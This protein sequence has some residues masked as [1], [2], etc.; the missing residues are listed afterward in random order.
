MASTAPPAAA[1]AAAAVATRDAATVLPYVRSV[2]S[3]LLADDSAIE[4]DLAQLDATLALAPT[5]AAVS[6]FAS[7]A[8]CPILVVQRAL[9]E[10]GSAPSYSVQLE[11]RHSGGA[12]SATFLALIKKGTV[13]EADKSL[14]QQLHVINLSED[15]PFETLHAYIHNAVSPFFN[16]CVTAK[17]DSSADPSS[18]ASS[19]STGGSSSAAAAGLASGS[20]TVKRKMA[21]L[22][23]SLLQLQQNVDIPEVDLQIHPLITQTIAKHRSAGTKATVDDF[24]VNDSTFVFNLQSCVDRWIKEIQKVTKLDR[25]PSHG[26]ALV[27][28]A[29]WVNLER[30]LQQVET[31]LAADDVVLTLDLLQRANRFTAITKFRSDIQLK[32]AMERVANYNVVMKNFPINEALAAP[33]VGRIITAVEDIFNHFKKL[34]GSQYPIPRAIKFVEAVSRDI[35]AHIVDVLQRRKLMQLPFDD[36]EQLMEHCNQLFRR[37][38][39]HLTSFKNM[40]RDVA[41]TSTQANRSQLAIRNELATLEERLGAVQEFRRHHEQ[42]RSVILRV[43]RTASFGNDENAVKAA[44]S[45]ANHTTVL[46]LSASGDSNTQAIDDINDAFETVKNVDVLDLTREG[47][48]LWESA[49]RAYDERVDRVET[50]ITA[51]LRDQLGTAK[52]ANEMFRIF[53]RFNALFVRPRIQGA[54]KEYQT[55]LIQR[56]KDDIETLVNKF[57]TQYSHS[58][59]SRMSTVRDIPPVSGSIIWAQQIE[60]QLK[61]YMRRVEDV[62]GPNWVKHV[63]GGK[64]KADGD[65]FARLLN[66]QQLYLKWIDDVTA[67]DPEVAGPLFEIVSIRSRAAL[68]AATLNAAGSTSSAAAA[69]AAAAA[70]PASRLRLGVNFD[71]QII[72]LFK[73]VRNLQWLA[74]RNGLKPVPNKITRVAHA[75]ETIYPF[76]VSLQE[77][78][79]GYSTACDQVDAL[80]ANAPQLVAGYKRDMQVLIAEGMTKSWDNVN[81]DKYITRLAAAAQTFQDKAE[82]LQAIHAKVAALVKSLATC[83]LDAATLRG[84]VSRIQN[85]VDELKLKGFSNLTSWASTL[86]AQVEGLLAVRLQAAVA[87]WTAA[88]TNYNT[89]VAAGKKPQF[90]QQMSII[91]YHDEN[92][93]ANAAAAAAAAADAGAITHPAGG[94]PTFKELTHEIRIRNQVMYLHPPLEHSRSHLFNQLHEWLRVVCGLPRIQGS[95]LAVDAGLADGSSASGAASHEHT[96]RTLV[97]KLAVTDPQALPKAL[98]AIEQRVAQVRDYVKDWLQYQA[99]W[100]LEGASVVARL[101]DDIQLW[102]QLLVEIKK[103]RATVDSADITASFG[104]IVV[105]FQQVQTKVNL[106]YDAWHKDILGRFGALMSSSMQDFYREI[107]TSRTDLEQHSVDAESTAEAVN[108]VTFVQ[109][110]KRKVRV[111]TTRMQAFR[112]GQKLL[113]RQ[114][115]QFPSDWLHVGQLEGEW[116]ALSEILARKDA[117][118]Q[119]QLASLRLKVIAED[120]ATAAKV[121]ELLAEWEAEKP[122]QGHLRPENALKCIA[123]FETRF[124]RARD[125]TERLNRAKEAL[126]ISDASASSSSASSSSGSGS[127]SFSDARLDSAAS[128]LAEL[129]GV[130]SELSATHLALDEIRDRPWSAV[131]SRKVRQSLDDMLNTLKNLPN[132]MRQYAGYDHLQNLLRG[133]IKINPLVGDLKSEALRERHW[134]LIAKRLRLESVPFTE[135]TLGH[136]YDADLA[137]NEKAVRDVLTVAQGEMGLEEFLRQVRDFWQAFQVDLVNYQNKTKLIRGWDDLFGKVKEH[138]GSITAMK[139][140]PYYKVFEEEGVSWED[141]L[142]RINALF[143]VWID[144]Q[145]RWVYLEGIFSGSADIKHLLPTETSRFANISTEFL[146]L[147]KKVTKSPSILDIVAIPNVQKS[148]ERL[149]DLLSKIQKGIGEYLERERSSFPRFYFVGDED[150]LEIIGNSKD[151]PKL[152]K[153]FRKMFAGINTLTLDEESTTALG[154]CSREGESV[155]FKS[156]VVIKDKR[157]NEWLAQV[158]KEMQMTLAHLLAEAVEQVLKFDASSF[159]P[160]AYLTWMDSFPT[161]LVVLGAQVAW[162]Q[163][164]ETNLTEAAK[165]GTS[166]AAAAGLRQVVSNVETTLAALADTVLGEQPPIRRRKLEHL[167]TELVHQRDV[168]REL[169]SSS[170]VSSPSSFEWLSQMRFYFDPKHADVLQRLTI[171]MAN[172]SFYYGFEYLGITDKLVQTPLTDRCYLTMTQALEERLGGSPFG[173]AGTGKTETVK[174]LGNQLGRFTLVFNCDE[175]FDFQA[176]GRIFVGL[177]HVGAWGCFD[178]FNRL[179]ERILSAVSQQVQ[180]I[181]LALKESTAATSKIEVELVGKTVRVNPAM[182]IFI[183]MNPGYAGRSNLPDNLKKLFRSLAMTQ[184]DRQLIAQVMLF[185]QGFRSAEQLARKIVPLFKLCS[186]QLSAQSHYDF[187]LRALKSVLVSAGNIK[188]SNLRRVR[189]QAERA[190]QTVDLSIAQDFASEQQVL[191]QSVVET[192][193]PKLVAD[194]IPLLYSLL[195][196]VFPGIEHAPAQL[197]ALKDAV[198]AVCNERH[199]IVGEA[200]LEKMLQLYQIQ[201]LHHGVMMVGPSGSGKSSAWNVLLE[202]MQR[203]DGVEGV[204][205]VLDPKAITK[206]RLYGTLDSTTREWTDGLFTHALRKIVDDVR[207]ESSKRHWIVFDG[208]VD[209]EW[210]ENLNSVL[211]DNKLLTLPN[212]ER[213]SIPPNVRIM[214]EVQDL[215]YATLATFF[216][217]LRVVSLDDEAGEAGAISSSAQAAASG[218]SDDKQLLVS[219]TMQVQRDAADVLAPH[220]A[221]GGLVLNALDYA[222]KQEHIMPFTRLRALGSL[223]SMLNKTV[224]N[225]ISYNSAHPDFPMEQQRIEQYVSRRLVYSLVWSLAGDAR[226]KVRQEL[227]EYIRGVTTIGLPPAANNQPIIDYEV[228]INGEWVLW[229]GKVPQIEIDTHRIATADVVVPTMDTVR[230]EDLLYTWLAEH[231]PLVLCGPP[232]SGKTMTLFSA[233]RALPELEVVGLNFSSATTPELLLRTLDHYCEYKRTPNGMVISPIQPGKWLVLFCDEINLPDL[234]KYGTQRVISFLRQLVQHGGFWRTSDHTW[235]QLDRIQFVGACNPPT[236]PGRKPLTERFLRHVPVVLVDYPGPASLSQIYGTFNRALLRLVPTLRSFTQPLTEAMVE[237]FT[238]SQ[239]RFTV[240][241]QPHYVYSPRELTRWVRGMYEAI[242]PLDSLPLEGLVR[243]W[244]HEALRLFQDRLVTDEERR[245]TDETVDAVAAKHFPTINMQTALARPILF[246]NW[247]SKEY[248]SVE[249]ETLREFVRA[250]LR[251]FYE[252]ELDVPLVLFNEVLDHVLRI[253]RVFR[254]MQG[255]MLLIGASGG[256]KTTLSRFVAWMTGL[257]VFQVK[258]HNRYTGADFEEDLR[259]I[260]RR[261]GCKG[262]RMCFIL[263]E[264][265]ILDASF[266]ERMNTLLANGEVPGLFEGDEF[267]TLMAQCKEGSQREGLMLDSQEELYKW[268]THQVMKNLHVVFTMN[269]SAEGLKD[270]ASTSPALFNR[271]VLDWFGDWSSEALFQVGREFTIKLDLDSS[272]YQAPPEHLFPIVAGVPALPSPTLQRDAISN[273]FVHVHRAVSEASERLLRRT[274]RTTFI[275]PRHYLDF[276][277]HYVELFTEK[278]TELEEQ[279]LHLNV[280]LSKIRETVD[281][282]EELQKSLAIKKTELE[283]KNELANV[284]LQQMVRDQQEAETKRVTSIELQAALEEQEKVITVKRASVLADLSQVEPAVRDA[285][286]AVQSIKKQHLTEIRSMANPPEMVK[287]AMEAVC[288]LLGESK[289]DWKDLRGVIIRDDFIPS[290]V[291]FKTEDLKDSTRVRMQKEFLSNP[292]F[293]FETVD[294]ASKACGPLVKWCIAQVGY[295]DMLRRIEPLRNELASLESAAT[296]NKSSAAQTNQLVQNLEASINKYKEE[297]AVLIAQAQSIRQEMETVKA[298]VER[299]IALLGSLSSE[300]TRWELESEQFRSQMST[301]TGDVLLAA[302]FLAYSGYFD[303]QHRLALNVNWSSHLQQAGIQHRMDL[304][305]TEF[306][307]TADERARW[308][309]NALPSD[310]L[311]TENAIMLRRHHRY[312]LIIDPSGQATKFLLNEFSARKMTK[313]SFLDEGFRKQLESALRFGNPLLV[314]DVENYDPI[315]NPVLNR[316]LRRAGGRILIRIGDQ[317]IDFS[318]TFAIFLTTRD[319]TVQFAPDIC[320]RVTFVNFTVT[321]S[322]LQGQCLNQVLRSER[323]D[324][325]QKRSDLL[326]LQGEFRLRLRHLE[327]EL[328]RALNESKG[329][330]LD[331]DSVITTLETLKGEAADIAKK[332]LE[333]DVVMAEVERVSNEYRPLALAC[334]SI[335]FTLDNLNQVHFLYQYSLQFFLDIF[336]HVISPQENTHLQGITDHAK[337]LDVLTHD[338]FS[339]LFDRVSRGLLHDD[340]IVLALL[341]ARIRLSGTPNQIDDTAF[342]VLL[343]GLESPVAAGAA[344]GALAGFSDEQNTRFRN[345]SSVSFFKEAVQGAGHHAAEWSSYVAAPAPETLLPTGIVP[346][347]GKATVDGFNNLL[348]VRALRPDRL[349]SASYHFVSSVFGD[350]FMQIAERDVDLANVVE[351]E[352]KANTPILL[353]SVP[354]YDASGRVDDLAAF[355]VKRCASI[356]IGS[357]EGFAL[358]EKAIASAVQTGDWVLLKNVHLAPSWLVTLEK[359]M[360]AVTAHANFRLFLTMEIHP[361]TPLSLVRQSRAFMFELPP[362]IKAN[363]LRT[364]SSVPSARMAAQPTERARLYFLTAWF[365]AVVQERLRYAPLG[366]SKKY[367]FTETDL[368]G[369]ID[370]LDTWLAIVSPPSQGRTNISPDAI[371]WEAIRTLLAQSIYGGRIDNE[372]DQRLLQSFLSVLFTPRSFDADHSLVLPVPGSTEPGESAAALA[373]L[374]VPDVTSADQFL[375]WVKALPDTQVPAWLGLPNTAEKVLLTSRGD[376]VISKLLK[377]QSMDEEDEIHVKEGKGASTAAAAAAAAADPRPAWMRSLQHSA[378]QWLASL[379]KADQLPALRRTRDNIKDPLFRCFEREVNMGIRLLRRVT[380]NLQHVVEA[381]QGKRKQTNNLRLL[382]SDFTKG[383]IPADWNK[384]VVPLGLTVNQWIVDFV[385]RIKQLQSIAVSS[386]LRRQTIWLAGLFVPEAYIT[387]TRQFV[388]QANKWSLEE[389]QLEI[390]VAGGAAAA[391]AGPGASLDEQSFLFSGLKLE[392]AKCEQNELSLAVSSVTS[393]PVAKMSWVRATPSAFAEAAR[394]QGK[395]NLPVYLNTTRSNLLLTVFIKA[396]QGVTEDVFYQ[397]GVAILCSSLKGAI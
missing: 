13:L 69:A 123:G 8:A 108:F 249:R 244:A 6:R 280:G 226:L 328:L 44:A 112:D 375:S 66:P 385:E 178:E 172:A 86:D 397:R 57:K 367:E 91:S 302:A 193:V 382:M 237:F 264:S 188:R 151:I 153:H 313:T 196:D 213:L 300:R 20:A 322:S 78:L 317:D 340:R 342:E 197:D 101:G 337:R 205:Y 79:R 279:Q 292:S 229:Q 183:T 106:K 268:F 222:A 241:Q 119:S 371:P 260:L 372:F 242:L 185:S 304:S 157:I 51:Y 134:K 318:P 14:A 139:L 354:G 46:A 130:W 373:H 202:A 54:I 390:D 152:Q 88:L 238:L 103:A 132:R 339:V 265:N 189:E 225:V 136:L 159:S 30:A 277:N 236:D 167:I 274:G 187:G 35:S 396:P 353:C 175:T 294:H 73:E 298:K 380:E 311:C 360:H 150:L 129:K 125:D 31:R 174:A 11:V 166:A 116:A 111:L 291:N 219:P 374:R 141:K 297:Y 212:G 121:G 347:T 190:G 109:D 247:L 345:L 177:C 32:E 62:L 343:R 142:N 306:L 154:I 191:I 332:V 240:D 53:S 18:S 384:Y 308:Q 71:S 149:A 176:M 163:S 295:A 74:E 349:V 388:A 145:R 391:A 75:A 392:G 221:P 344:G 43:L 204:S 100:D 140:S 84:I 27:E 68:A 276:I 217:K 348:L 37:F 52:N 12:R 272:S 326:K 245:W 41:R 200:W 230:H 224:R 114:R 118:I 239:E 160:D 5:Q 170:K 366:W 169:A 60:R 1:A 76:A 147:M 323:P 93:S 90:N 251:V 301:I 389:L 319:P 98:A 48:E 146:G 23:L 96:Y 315:L 40:I 370:T 16:S 228:G 173:P 350:D 195:V 36:F 331:D 65:N 285:Q 9:A 56:V 269:P 211:D 386:D 293:K 356:A 55:K 82:D 362:G 312:P 381:C 92:D 58:M 210:V 203:V 283:A 278:R 266:L 206:D 218:S 214:F 180:T 171:R 341:L 215:R 376:L 156:A 120:R 267:T 333:T 357:A 329:K 77:T 3:V 299:S 364:F 194:D 263:D 368:R 7:D 168:T 270:R 377:M 395:V 24:D 321:P 89:A 275:T 233:L 155:P 232:G 137:K 287:L 243:V 325:D 309:A 21:E 15:N 359:K 351:R 115:F 248:V 67:R 83:A 255:H 131:V 122:V 148:L 95:R 117:A 254:Q 223:F 290:I 338:L 81:L 327:K 208:D 22:E 61:T 361:K 314:Q 107:G 70:G 102:Q 394:G 186:E 110:L 158:E 99:L 303:Q 26:S 42:L 253:D 310:D 72:T 330:I 192:L 161:Q 207:N 199:L 273:A 133:L 143:D 17:Q 307:S 250:R 383:L 324:V 28:I 334:S 184:P 201:T 284:K 393:L 259:E 352:V 369:A 252:E 4:A 227:G 38:A 45:I 63:E 33:D 258:V 355:K 164:V 50:Q 379:P 85:A 234:D 296:A 289:L 2:V 261:S 257:S 59:A 335:F 320:S 281:Q 271:C 104:P 80:D 179:E 29:F 358:A 387:A 363:M 47:L 181:Q 25:D 19:S 113:E 94:I 64:L 39:V 346:A 105:N 220:F 144:V 165:A 262:E 162:S 336:R 256:G 138:L 235:I 378:E 305:L 246:S 231:K 49:K 87:T 286:S 135:L 34:R 209:P 128:E 182:G 365:H 127:A 10:T 97:V 288:V 282:V 316:E 216:R 124:Q 126:D 198:R